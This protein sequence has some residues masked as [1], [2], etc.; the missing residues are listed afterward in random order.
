M[1]ENKKLDLRPLFSNL[2]DVLYTDIIIM[3]HFY[4]QGRKSWESPL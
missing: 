2:K 4:L 3:L 1:K